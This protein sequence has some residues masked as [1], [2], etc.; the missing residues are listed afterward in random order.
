MLA[1]LIVLALSFGVSALWWYWRR[2]R[3]K[4][5]TARERGE[6]KYSRD[7]QDLQAMLEK[8]REPVAASRTEKRDPTEAEIDAARSELLA[9]QRPAVLVQRHWPPEPRDVPLRSYFGGRPRLAEEQVWPIDKALSQSLTFIGQVDI[10]ELP[11]EVKGV[12]QG[13]RGTLSFFANTNFEGVGDPVHAVLHH[14]GRGDSVPEREFPSDLMPAGGP[15]GAARY[16][17][18]QESEEG[19]RGDLRQ[20]MSFA[21]FT[22][23][24]DNDGDASISLG[25]PEAH[26]AAFQ[27]LQMN[28]YRRAL[29]PQ[30][31]PV[32]QTRPYDN[33]SWPQAWCF[34]EHAARALAH[35][36]SSSTND[37]AARIG[38]E[39]LGWIQQASLASSGALPADL[40][41][42]FR[43]WWRGALDQLGARHGQAR[44]L[45]YAE[46][47]KKLEVLSNELAI[48]LSGLADASAVAPMRHGW[49]WSEFARS[50]TCATANLSF[51]KHQMFGFGAMIQWSAKE[52]RDDILLLELATID[53]FTWAEWAGHGALQFWISPEALTAGRFSEV[54]ATFETD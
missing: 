9:H 16:P 54:V 13:L 30:T 32:A 18:L 4:P 41:D 46:D 10:E 42:S 47:L 48:G 25:E 51:P 19:A 34:V 5:L 21:A 26:Q 27:Q 20:K 45:I 3:R 28:A 24:L 15:Y 43:D 6:A 38:S 37:L 1:N 40:H 2:P 49:T 23:F 44:P 22:S 11:A 17:W 35:A 31:L 50:S 12:R 52:H 8:F 39:A 36:L 29:G 14:A 33:V 53:N 7:V